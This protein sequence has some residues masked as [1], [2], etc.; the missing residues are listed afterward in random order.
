MKLVDL[1]VNKKPALIWQGMNFGIDPTLDPELAL[2]LRVSLEEERARQEQVQAAAAGDETMAEA[3]PAE[4][5]AAS[6]LLLT[7]YFIFPYLRTC[8]AQE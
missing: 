8:Q 7:L 2:A 4:G 1:D 3:N 6:I 5:R